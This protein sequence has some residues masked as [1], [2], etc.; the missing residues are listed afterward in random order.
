MDFSDPVFDKVGHN[1]IVTTAGKKCVFRFSKSTE[2]LYYVDAGDGYASVDEK[3]M[4]PGRVVV[5]EDSLDAELPAMHINMIDKPRR[6]SI[7]KM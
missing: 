6:L 2:Y 7:I 3:P 5:P 4:L 1:L